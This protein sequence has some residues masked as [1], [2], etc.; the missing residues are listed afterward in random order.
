MKFLFFIITLFCVHLIN[1]EARNSSEIKK[2]LL[3]LS[4]DD[5]KRVKRWQRH[6][7]S[8]HALRNNDMFIHPERSPFD[9]I[10][11]KEIDKQIAMDYQNIGRV[12]QFADPKPN[13]R[14]FDVQPR[15]FSTLRQM[16]YNVF[17]DYNGFFSDTKAERL[18]PYRPIFIF[19]FVLYMSY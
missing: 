18:K 1:P 10:S 19:L 6:G 15:C 2:N 3:S 13:R 8:V 17:G 16:W 9:R 11:N 5:D 7:H 4:D 12:E 14:R